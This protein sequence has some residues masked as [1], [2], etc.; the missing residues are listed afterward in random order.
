MTSTPRPHSRTN[1]D[2]TEAGKTFDAPYLASL[3]TEWHL[4]YYELSLSRTNEVGAASK[5]SFTAALPPRSRS[6]SVPQTRTARERQI[7]SI[8]IK[9]SAPRAPEDSCC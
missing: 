5:P 6:T 4:R 1:V 3:S 9:G 7:R 8:N 2:R